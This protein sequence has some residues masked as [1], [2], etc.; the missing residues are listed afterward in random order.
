MSGAGGGGAAASG[1]VCKV[2]VGGAGGATGAGAGAAGAGGVGAAGAGGVA[3][4][5]AGAGSVWACAVWINFMFDLLEAA[6][7]PGAGAR[8]QPT[9]ADYSR[10]HFEINGG[11]DF[12]HRAAGRWEICS[13]CA[14]THRA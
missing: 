12:A 10:P 11:A 1:G 7:P 6:D 9:G 2:A 3:A 5:G 8:S 14:T 13:S 4:S